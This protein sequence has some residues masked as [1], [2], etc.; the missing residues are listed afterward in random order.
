MRG[1]LTTLDRYKTWAGISGSASDSLLERLI[2]SASTFIVS[3]LNKPVHIKSY[4]EKRNGNGS[5][6]LVLR[7]WPVKEVSAV[8][9]NGQSIPES[10]GSTHGFLHDGYNVYLVGGF[11]AFD[12]GIQNISVT[13]DAGFYLEDTVKVPEEVTPAQVV[14]SGLSGV[15]VDDFSVVNSSGVALTK[16]TASPATALQYSVNE[17]G[18]YLF[19]DSMVGQ[20]VTITYGNAPN[21]V[22]QACMELVLSRSKEKDRIGISSKSVANESISY[23]QKDLSNFIK[24]SLQNYRAVT[25]L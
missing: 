24:T 17:K 5:S 9:I 6:T 18:V 21:D 11:Y 23:S 20:N 25:P 12:K 7:N 2:S 15:W 14:V 13:Y 3:W 4:V 1:D 16:V 22:E 8:T 19:H 10:N